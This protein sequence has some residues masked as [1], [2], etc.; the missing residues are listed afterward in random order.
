MAAIDREGRF[1]ATVVDYGLNENKNGI[2]EFTVE[3]AASSFY[4]NGTWHDWTEYAQ[5]IRGYFYAFKKDGTPN[6]TTIHNLMDALGWDG[7]SMQSLQ[8]GDY[9]NREVQIVV[10]S[11]T[12]EGAARLKVAWLDPGD[13]QPSLKKM[14]EREV[15]AMAATWDAK[16]RALNAGKAKGGNSAKPSPKAQGAA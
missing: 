4:D 15:K 3:F 10:K 9:A 14:D 13:H 11:E 8:E 7:L 6:T 16:L 5:T 1:K 12:Y 2:P